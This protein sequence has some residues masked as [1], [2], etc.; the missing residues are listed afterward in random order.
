MSPLFRR[1]AWWLRGSRKE[2][3]L[4]EELQFHLTEEAEDRR[5]RGL[6]DDEARWAA[7]RDLGNEARVREDVR[8]IWT[9]RPL[10]ELQQDVRYAWRTG[11]PSLCARR[12]SRE[13][14]RAPS[15]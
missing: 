5:T 14:P 8:A 12:P 9:W 10:E 15:G 6:R 7:Q 1:L 2:A 11:G 13:R 4:R 3:E